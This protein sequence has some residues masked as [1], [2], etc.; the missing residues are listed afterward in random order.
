MIN[1]I[2]IVC[3][4]IAFYVGQK[5]LPYVVSTLEAQ[6]FAARSPLPSV[7]IYCH[8][9]SILFWLFSPWIAPIIEKLPFNWGHWVQYARKDFSWLAKGKLSR[10][11]LGSDTYWTVGPG[12]VALWSSDA[13]VISQVVHRWKDFSKLV[14]D[15]LALNAYGKNV[16]TTDG[17]DWQRHRKITGPPFNERN[18]GCVLFL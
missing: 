16:V 5:L 14:D 10:D 6:R 7:N 9:E 8:R 3:G 1:L 11:E 15:Y 18:S 17:A 13:D 12:G 4:L 2:A